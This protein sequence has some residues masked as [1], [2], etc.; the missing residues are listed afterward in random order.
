M[1]ATRRRTSRWKPRDSEK[2]EKNGEKKRG[3]RSGK[4]SNVSQLSLR[5]HP[6]PDAHRG[7]TSAIQKRGEE[8][9]KRSLRGSSKKRGTKDPQEQQQIGA[10]KKTAGG[11]ES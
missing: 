10:I 4:T 5:D 6:W 9:F 7:L 2:D 8:K 11:R 3:K 1:E